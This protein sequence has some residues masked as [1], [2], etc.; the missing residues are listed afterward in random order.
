M[1][2]TL[3]PYYFRIR[4]NGAFV[5]RVDTVDRQRR[6]AMEQIATVNLK[7]G[8]IKAHG[9]R[10]LSDSD[11]AA[12][13]DWMG[14]RGALLARREIDDIHRTIDHLNLTAQWA[15]ARASDAALDEVADA[16]L[17]AMHDLR[18]VLVRR[19]A[20]QLLAQRGDPP[21][22]GNPA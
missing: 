1:S 2:D 18:M 13:T 12:I 19:R 5:Y 20:D 11:R 15:Q 7:N 21:P 8:T 6:I 17:L 9:E 10:A 14:Q 4:D 3:P 22:E 16:L